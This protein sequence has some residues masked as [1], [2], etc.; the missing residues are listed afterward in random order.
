MERLSAAASTGIAASAHLRELLHKLSRLP[1]DAN[2]PKAGVL[3]LLPGDYWPKDASGEDVPVESLSVTILQRV[4]EVYQK[5]DGRRPQTIRAAIRRSV[6]ERRAASFAVIDINAAAEELGLNKQPAKANSTNMSTPYPGAGAPSS[7]EA[8]AGTRNL[9]PAEPWILQ[10]LEDY[11]PRSIERF[12]PQELRYEDE[13]GYKENLVVCYDGDFLE[14]LYHILCDYE[15]SCEPEKFH[16]IF[17]NLVQRRLTDTNETDKRKC[18]T[19][20][21]IKFAHKCWNVPE[22]YANERIATVS[23]SKQAAGDVCGGHDTQQAAP[24]LS[25][26]DNL[27]APPLEKEQTPPNASASRQNVSDAGDVVSKA[28]SSHAPSPELAFT[29]PRNR[30]E[31]TQSR[32][33]SQ[34]CKRDGQSFTQSAVPVLP[35]HSNALAA[36]N[37][38]DVDMA[39]SSQSSSVLPT[40]NSVRRVEPAAEPYNIQNEVAGSDDGERMDGIA[41]SGPAGVAPEAAQTQAGELRPTD[42]TTLVDSNQESSS[43]STYPHSRNSRGGSAAS[44]NSNSGERPQSEHGLAHRAETIEDVKMLDVPADE[45]VNES[46]QPAATS[47]VEPDSLVAPKTPNQTTHSNNTLSSS[48]SNA[49][50]SS[51]TRRHSNVRSH[52]PLHS[53]LHSVESSTSTSDTTDRALINDPTPSEPEM[54]SGNKSEIHLDRP[55]PGDALQNATDGQDTKRHDSPM[56]SDTGV[57]KMQAEQTDTSVDEAYSPIDAEVAVEKIFNETPSHEIVADDELY[58]GHLYEDEVDETQEGNEI[59]VVEPMNH[60]P[61]PYAFNH[62]AQTQASEALMDN[63]YRSNGASRRRLV[64]YCLPCGR[65]PVHGATIKIQLN[66]VLY[67]DL[68]GERNKR[69]GSLPRM[70]RTD[71]RTTNS[72]RLSPAKQLWQ[73][74]TTS[75]VELLAN[76]GVQKHKRDTPRIKRLGFRSCLK[77]KRRSIVSAGSPK[78][79]TD[80]RTDINAEIVVQNG[81]KSMVEAYVDVLYYT[82]EDQQMQEANGLIAKYDLARPFRAEK[83]HGVTYRHRDGSITGISLNLGVQYNIFE[84][85]RIL[86]TQRVIKGYDDILTPTNDRIDWG[87]MFLWRLV[88][89][90]AKELERAV[91]AHMNWKREKY[92][93]AST[94]PICSFELAYEDASRQPRNCYKI[95]ACGVSSKYRLDGIY[96]DPKLEA[97]MEKFRLLVDS[98]ERALF[99]GRKKQWA[100]MPTYES[101]EVVYKWDDEQGRFVVAASVLRF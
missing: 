20:A 95:F 87:I 100:H 91:Q 89:R 55:M 45:V 28:S 59:A 60:S 70:R 78:A 17:I 18:L 83:G 86:D 3:N 54:S 16:Q 33:T 90:A 92:G 77:L 11:Y 82:G 62:L 19:A 24:T 21:D 1:G 37:F 96:H 58:V 36:G 23:T 32:A 72:E 71:S 51:S 39:D 56:E 49:P 15:E 2:S 84:L 7:S 98:Y 79:A 5:A 101:L 26:V 53:V 22:E 68:H 10:G 50:P 67:H 63:V 48:R 27:Q 81:V 52:S 12:V 93:P 99:R 44:S 40:T 61:A 66:T 25:N 74:Q 13:L 35:G 85:E 9:V 88:E 64:L 94:A 57:E 8:K 14:A 41:H 47:S 69:T 73:E 30:L 76:S 75:F 29:A 43:G 6:N 80:S 42:T 38:G 46:S 65:N 31:D 4:L 34:S 97:A